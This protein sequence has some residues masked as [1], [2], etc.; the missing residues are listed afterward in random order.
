MSH[1]ATGK[2]VQPKIGKVE[3][4]FP[5]IMGEDFHGLA[6]SQFRHHL[7]ISKQLNV[8][9]QICQIFFREFG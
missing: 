1:C 6:G 7:S 8:K 5:P 3:E 2:V 9:C 4:E